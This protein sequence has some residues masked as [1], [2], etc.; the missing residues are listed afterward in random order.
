MSEATIEAIESEA[1]G[2]GEAIEGEAYEGEAYGEAGYEAYGE[3]ARSRA[4]RRARQ[5]QIM[6]ARQRQQRRPVRPMPM[7]MPSPVRPDARAAVNAIRTVDLEAKVAQDSLRRAIEN[8]NRRA[9][10][11]TYSAL[12]TAAIGQVLDT[13]EKNLDGHPF[14][15]AAARFAPLAILP[16]DRERKGIEAV[17]LHPAFIGGALIGGIFVLGKFTT[18]SQDVHEIKIAV[19]NVVRD[20]DTGTLI[21]TPVDRNGRTLTGVAVSWKSGED[22]IL[23]FTDPAA[24]KFK[25]LKQG[26]VAVTV[27]AGDVSTSTALRVEANWATAGGD[28]AAGA[29]GAGADAAGSRAAGGSVAGSNVP[30]DPPQGN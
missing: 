30:V 18:T 1:Y 13:Y 6:L 28:G 11:A 14:V 2:E 16:G 17:L 12:A 7:P 24:G 15:R 22:T 29:N 10:R 19:P 21:A 3:D 8:A 26:P 4:N 27:T 9:S 23:M 20:G 5:R 25:A